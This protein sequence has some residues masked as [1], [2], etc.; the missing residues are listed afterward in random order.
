LKFHPKTRYKRC[1]CCGGCC[2]EVYVYVC[3]CCSAYWILSSHW[4]NLHFQLTF[5]S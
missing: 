2:S 1:C 3:C 4:F 5:L